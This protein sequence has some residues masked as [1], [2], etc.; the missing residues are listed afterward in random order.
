MA[1]H[2][3]QVILAHPSDT[4]PLQGH[5]LWDTRDGGGDAGVTCLFRRKFT[6]EEAGHRPLLR[7]SADSRYRAFLNGTLISRGPSR[8]TPEFYHYETVDLADRL[9]DGENV[10]AAEVRWY[11]RKFE[12][13]AEVHQT[14]GFWAML[15]PAENPGKIVTDAAWR[16][17][18]SPT[19]RLISIPRNHPVSGW[20]HVI[21]PTE[22]T[23]FSRLPETWTRPGY[24]DADWTPVVVLEP[25]IGRYQA[26]SYYFVGHELIGREIPPLEE[27]PVSPGT[28]QQAG[29][30]RPDRDP[31]SVREIQGTLT[32][33]NLAWP[34]FS[35]PLHLPEAG[36]HY[37]IVNAGAL[38][39]GYPRLAITAPAGTLVEFRYAEALSQNFKKTVRDDPACTV[40][41]YYDLFTCRKGRTVVEPFVWRTFRFLRIAVHHPAGPVTLEKL[42]TIF[43]AYPF[44]QQATFESSDPLHRTLWDVSWHTAR[45]CAHETY[46]DCPYYEQIQY[47]LDTQLQSLVG[48][49]VAGD[50]RL[51]RQALRQFA[52]S[53]RYDGIISCRAPA[54]AWEPTII[55]NLAFVWIEY[56]EDYYRYSGDGSLVEELWDCLE[57]I[58][59]W[60]DQFLRD[61]VLDDVPYWVFT[62]WTL[63]HGRHICGSTGE[64]NLRRIGAL[65]SASRLATALGRADRAAHFDRDLANAVSAVKKVF[66]SDPEKLF[67]DEPDGTLVAEHASVLAVLYGLIEPAEGRQLLD[68]LAKRTDLA[69]MSIS[70]AYFAFRAAQKIGYYEKIWSQRLHNW[71]DQLA[72]HATTWFETRE[73]S[74]SDCHGWGSWIM[75]DLL[76]AV[77]GIQPARPGFTEVRI[78]PNFLNLEWA[79]GTIPTVRGAIAVAWRR[80]KNRVHYEI[81][82]P[83]N[84]PG[85]L[86]LPNGTE[87]FISGKIK[88][89]EPLP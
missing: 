42:E 68:R 63:P 57:G 58:F 67:V 55:P 71:T 20:Y 82:L 72:L 69:K 19:H 32:P 87:K 3:N 76:T 89:S 53:R 64:L 49:L 80:E 31:Q 24:D 18:R 1:T 23:D 78:A 56:L 17:R 15:G 27:T 37:L 21:D 22:D 51:A 88:I 62:D 61:G 43:T 2:S 14:P 77:L 66:W 11:G 7:I 86:V 45:L 83:E 73:P 74:R 6:R 5:W 34:D 26:K 44:R 13:R 46:E 81:E 48:Y 29:T 35:K 85:I 52:A 9:A 39:T 59:K 28:V 12:P 84:T 41:G 79:H 47:E 65:G 38:T 50:F 70:L 60:F 54:V 8:G 75:T 16:V 10:L 30:I 25:A 40:E 33:A 4:V 36:T